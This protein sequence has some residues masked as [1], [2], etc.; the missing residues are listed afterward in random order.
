MTNNPDLDQARKWANLKR[1]TWSED[2]KAA[3]EVI[4]SLPDE[5]VDA[6]LITRDLPEPIINANDGNPE[7]HAGDHTVDVD[8]GMVNLWTPDGTHWELT[9]NQA[10]NLADALYAAAD[11][12]E[13]ENSH[14]DT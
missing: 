6:R 10:R 11:Y 8:W 5:W 12:A 9:S 13:E 14:A 3:A 2:S 7:W 4:Q 1:Y